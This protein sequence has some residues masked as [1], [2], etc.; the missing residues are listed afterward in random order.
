ME[1][2]EFP[3][4][5]KLVQVLIVVKNW[6]L[7]PSDSAVERALAFYEVETWAPSP[8]PRMI[9]CVPPGIIPKHCFVC[10]LPK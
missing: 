8:T 5:R 10:P 9:P 3:F 4:Y 1:Y 7:D 6:S 2:C